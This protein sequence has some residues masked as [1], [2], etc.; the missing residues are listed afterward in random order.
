MT[1]KTRCFWRD[2]SLSVLLYL[3]THKQ[4]NLQTNRL[5]DASWLTNLLR[6]Q[7]A[8]PD[9]VRIQSSSSC[10]LKELVIFDPRHVT[11]LSPIGK[12]T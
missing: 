2:Q 11:R 5:L 7:G 9:H 1:L 3:P 8:R 12:R 6:F 10:S 4:K